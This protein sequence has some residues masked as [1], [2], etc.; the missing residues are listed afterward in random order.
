VWLGFAVLGLPTS[1]LGCA[2]ASVFACVADEQ[3]GD[4]GRCEA[5]GYCSFPDVTCDSGRR[6]GELSGG[7]IAGTC[8]PEDDTA[9]H[10]SSTMGDDGSTSVASTSMSTSTG[11]ITSDS[12]SEATGSDATAG[13]TSTTSSMSSSTTSDTT[14]ETVERVLDGLLAFYPLD[15]AAG[16]VVVDQSNVA[17]AIDM[18]IVGSGFTWTPTGLHTDGTGIVL[19]QTSADKIHT[20]CQVTN[21]LTLE[22][23]ITP[24]H[25]I[26][27]VITQPGRIVT[28][29]Q[30]MSFRN[31]TLGQGTSLDF[32]MGTQE[33][34]AG[35]VRTTDE[36]A[37]NGSPSLY[38]EIQVPL[39]AQHVMYT[40]RADGVEV[41]YRDGQAIGSHDVK[42]GDFSTWDASFSLALGNEVNLSRPW[43]G[44]LHLVA[45]Y[46]RALDEAEVVQNYEAG[47]NGP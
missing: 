44:E 21:E 15:E 10:G 40:R 5:Q 32:G 38:A 14:G 42:P 47:F 18:D 34:F 29:S 45:I 11:S 31:F 13:E 6:Y 20:A 26:Q 35:R 1:H 30:T 4:E 7:K 12:S 41:L 23:W 22:A 3:C 2:P 36:G 17:P 33:G 39:Q 19:A 28:Y 8:V 9:G 24:D 27:P 37:E 43:A 46:E 16:T 25:V